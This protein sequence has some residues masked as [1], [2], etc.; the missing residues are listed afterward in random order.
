MPTYQYNGSIT[1]VN[2]TYQIHAE[3]GDV[4]T[5]PFVLP[6]EWSDFQLTDASDI[7]AQITNTLRPII[8]PGGKVQIN[9]KDY[10]YISILKGTGDGIIRINM[11]SNT[12][13]VNTI[14]DIG[15][16]LGAIDID[17]QEYPLID[18]ITLEGPSTNTE[19]VEAIVVRSQWGIRTQYAT[20][21]SGG[22]G[23][24]S[25]GIDNMTTRLD[26]EGGNNIIYAGYAQ[27][28]SEETDPV[29]QIRKMEY[30]G[31]GNLTS[32]KFA[33]GTA[34]FDKIWNNRDSYTYGS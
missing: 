16:S 22:S 13:V 25:S 11:I 33:G 17:M 24:S 27:P 5:T 26:Y 2:N 18:T 10:A 29:W 21:S 19:S 20:S 30:D 8:P 15:D 14:A 28:G 31:N 7:D 23:T 6:S 12:L 9:I 34:A 4:I 32:V 1:F 3:P